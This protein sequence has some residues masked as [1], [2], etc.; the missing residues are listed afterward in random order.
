MKTLSR[1]I[2]Q[3][4]GHYSVVVVGSGY[5]GAITASRIARA[6]RD[7]CVLERGKELHSG[8]Y[9]NSMLSALREIQVHAPG[10]DLGPDSGLFDFHAGPDITVLAG[11]GLGGTSL[12]NANVALEPGEEIFADSRWPAPLRHHPEV[13]KPFLQAAKTMLGSVPYP[14][15]WPEPPKLT[16]LGQVAR[17]LGR[18]VS[19]PDI[20]VT[21]TDGPNAAGVRQNACVLCGDCCSG[22]NY[23]AKNSVL[24]NYLPDAHAHGAHIFTEVAVSSVRRWQGRW[25]VGYDVLSAGLR[26]RPAAER[27][28]TADVV[29]LA[30]GTL[31]STSILLRSREAG[32]PLSDRLGHGFSGNGDVLAFAYDTDTPVHGVGLGDDISRAG[33]LVGPAITGLIDLRG[34]GADLSTALIIEEG[35]IP[36]ALAPMLP[37]L[38]NAASYGKLGDG[39]VPVARR[40]RE[41]AGGAFG[42][43][44]GPVNRTLTYLVMST[45]DSGG[46][47]TL[48]NDR[49]RVEWPGVAG[50]SVFARD[51]QVLATATRALHGVLAPDPLWTLTGGRSLIT[52]HPLGGCVMADDVGGG[53]VDHAGRVFDPAG[54]V[55]EGLYV[56][57]GSVIPLALDANPLLTIAGLAER[58]AAI[59]IKDRGWAP[60]D[61]AGSEQAPVAGADTETG[62]APLASLE[63]SERLTGFASMSVPDDYAEGYARGRDDG[64]SVELLLTIRYDDAQAML[65]DPRRPARISGTVL[66]PE[67]SPDPLTVTEGSFTLLAPDPS[68][69]ETWHMTYR[70]RLMPSGGTA[71]SAPRGVPDA[72]PSRGTP[73]GPQANTPDTRPAEGKCYSL[74]GHKVIR[75]HG[76]RHAWSETTTLYVTIAGLDGPDAAPPARGTGIVHLK[77]A[78][79][80]RLL[81]GITV[82]GVPR[83]R[84]EE[85]R[86]KFL[87]LFGFEMVHIYGG[88]LDEASAFPSAPRNAP[89]VR[90]PKSADGTWWCDGSRQW[91]AGG[92]LGGDAFARLTRYRAGD[93]G[94][95]MLASGF[96]MSSHSFLAPTIEVN[97]TEF[98]ASHGYDV[99]LFDYRAG[100]DLPSS[101]TEFTIDD[102]AR[103]DWP[104]AVRQVLDVTGRES[105]LAFG[106][107]VG[108]VSLQMAILAGLQEIR[109]AVCAQFPMHP[110]SSAF[111]RLKARLHAANAFASA[112][113]AG[114]APDTGHSPGDELLDFALRA[115]PMPAEE[116]C[117]QAVCRW[118]NA[119]YGGTHRHAQLNDATHRALNDMFGFGNID[120][121][122]HLSLMMGHGLAVTATGGDDYFE[123][124]ERLA[125]TRLLLLQGMKNRIFRPVGMLRTLGWLRSAN[126]EGDFRLV[127]LPGYAHLDAI[128]GARA[129]I[130]VFPQVVEFLDRS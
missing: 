2:D 29:V 119:I 95:V 111:N 81:R 126:P 60:A 56:C 10:A 18:E 44:H 94:P 86:R 117:G 19:R 125:G 79:F 23:G 127:M 83:A 109:A 41:L 104:A 123:H 17:S 107:C 93:K 80:P 110:A 76:T 32:L 38:L 20:N 47:I 65:N 54:G 4:L 106:H 27:F 48:D 21:F 124:P 74:E 85:Y 82:S 42:A 1:S 34:P 122:E 59:M 13:L 116:R 88:A 36:G 66:A 103:V 50:Q 114:V 97:L 68:R 84:Q 112:G 30:A 7:V 72:V 24:M 70:M 51:D 96:G 67:L 58:T 40:L 63:F 75:K 64:T 14:G 87:E 37:F 120:S 39:P 108:S 28:I 5:G 128:V 102:I 35:S 11:C 45:D 25:R 26:Q 78:D 6:G 98:L 61:R 118:V 53:V 43:H 101:G 52:V 22:C 49:A 55:H 100:I 73:P 113:I 46:R 129:A 90:E 92:T 57:D 91:H 31:G 9:P 16:A 115:V 12:I 69:A 8:E 77:P 3:L 62:A 105:L 15:D 99:W 89:P 33:T 121:L 71:A 130:D